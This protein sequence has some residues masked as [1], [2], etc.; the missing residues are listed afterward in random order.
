MIQSFGPSN[1]IVEPALNGFCGPR[2]SNNAAIGRLSI[3]SSPII[4]TVSPMRRDCILAPP[5]IAH[6]FEKISAVMHA[7]PESGHCGGPSRSIVT[8][9]SSE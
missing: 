1:V 9:A 2:F 7:N 6:C 4:C 3:F 5:T 8:L